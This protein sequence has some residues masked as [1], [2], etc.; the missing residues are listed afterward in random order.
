MFERLI[1]RAQKESSGRFNIADLRE[2]WILKIVFRMT[3]NSFSR[4][5]GSYLVLLRSVSTPR[6]DDYEHW[7]YFSIESI[8]FQCCCFSF[9]SGKLIIMLSTMYIIICFIAC[10]LHYYTIYRRWQSF[11]R[12]ASAVL[13]WGRF[14]SLASQTDRQPETWKRPGCW[15]ITHYL[16]ASPVPTSTSFFDVELVIIE[17]IIFIIKYDCVN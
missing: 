4:Q 9:S 6:S 12:G 15:R 14:R 2:V 13:S 8:C 1:G 10:G 17:A 7:L 16:V 5:F 3:V 11:V